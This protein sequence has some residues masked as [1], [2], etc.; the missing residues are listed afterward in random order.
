MAAI[1]RSWWRLGALAALLLTLAGS[2]A[3]LEPGERLADP[4]LEQRARVISSELRC[5]VCPNQSIDDSNAPLAGDLRRVVRERLSAGDSD[6]QVIG[7]VTAR[8]G[9][10]VLL[11]PPV[12]P[13]TYLL[14]FGPPL[15]LALAG[16]GIVLALRRRRRA[17]STVPAPLSEAERHRLDALLRDDA[18]P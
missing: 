16:A 11:R 2:A 10:F 3:A 17:A 13:N 9:D 18:P 8:Y 1:V 14:W 7:F 5:L 4:A 12:Q 15:L 6:Q